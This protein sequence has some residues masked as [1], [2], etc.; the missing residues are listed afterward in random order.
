MCNFC[1]V[2][3]IVCV[4]LF[5]VLFVCKCVLYY[6]HRV[7]TQLQLTNI[8]YHI[9]QMLA[10][11]C[12]YSK[13][14]FLNYET[15]RTSGSGRCSIRYSVH[16]DLR[17]VASATSPVLD[18]TSKGRMSQ[19]ERHGVPPAKTQDKM[20][21]MDKHTETDTMHSG[22]QILARIKICI[23][24]VF[25]TYMFSKYVTEKKKRGVL[26]CYKFL[27]IC[28]ALFC[29]WKQKMLKKH[30]SR[31]LFFKFYMRLV[32]ELFSCGHVNEEESQRIS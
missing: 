31:H 24:N 8:S 18:L 15:P 11:L 23:F 25:V 30:R 12:L 27:Q 19:E 3:R 13:H 2:L 16:H 32:V 6:C 26:Y 14:G 10:L 7:T 9:L 29:M 4:V 1:V 21:R 5:C 17:R 28:V 20:H 22:V